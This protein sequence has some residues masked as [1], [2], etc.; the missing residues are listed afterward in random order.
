[1]NA[2]SLRRAAVMGGDRPADPAGTMRDIDTVVAAMRTR[3]TW[4]ESYVERPLGHKITPV[5][6][7]RDFT[8]LPPLLLADRADVDDDRL[9][10]LAADA[11]RAIEARLLRGQRPADAVT[12]VIEKVFS[13]DAGGEQIDCLPLL[14]PDYDE[15]VTAALRD[16]HRFRRIVEA[17]LSI[18]A[19]PAVAS[20]SR[21]P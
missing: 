8:D 13:V 14:S 16:P 11:L 12:E 5:I 21:Q 17:V 4:Y 19:E 10:G 6:G 1:V 3:P 2:W 9:A 18:V 15:H 7:S 20:S